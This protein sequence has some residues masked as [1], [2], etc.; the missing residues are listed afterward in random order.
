MD[1]KKI[2]LFANCIPVKGYENSVICDLQRNKIYKID[3]ELFKILTTYKDENIGAIKTIYK[4]EYDEIITSFVSQLL[5]LEV[6]FLAGSTEGFP[7]IK[8]HYESPSIIENAIIEYSPNFKH[9][10]RDLI[11]SFNY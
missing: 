8:F 3:N 9:K 7:S 11:S 6:C 1:Q 10:I 5:S 4:N 2:N